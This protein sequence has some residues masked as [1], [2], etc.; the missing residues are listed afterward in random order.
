[1]NKLDEKVE[2]MRREAKRLVYAKDSMNAER[3]AQVY[4]TKN[5]KQEIDRTMPTETEI[6]K[7]METIIRYTDRLE[8]LREELSK[9]TQAS[10]EAANAHK[11]LCKNTLLELARMEPTLTKMRRMTNAM[12]GRLDIIDKLRAYVEEELEK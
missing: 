4:A 10:S 8:N 6:R 1:M 7:Q 3:G 9:V 2:D 11:R 5:L 12:V